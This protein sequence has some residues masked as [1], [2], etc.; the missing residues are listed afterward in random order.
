MSVKYSRDDLRGLISDGAPGTPYVV[1]ALRNLTCSSESRAAVV[2]A[3]A[4]PWLVALVHD[5]SSDAQ[6]FAPCCDPRHLSMMRQM[7]AEALELLTN[8]PTFHAAIVD[9]GAVPS[10]VALVRDGVPDVRKAGRTR[11]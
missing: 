10:L 1:R 5:G 11:C 8:S 2:G 6:T 7:A 4:I 9:A 3:G